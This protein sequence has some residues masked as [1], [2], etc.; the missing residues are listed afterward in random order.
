MLNEVMRQTSVGGVRSETY[1]A[2]PDIEGAPRIGV[3]RVQFT[4]IFGID[5][6]GR[7]PPRR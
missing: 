6:E 5:R 1:G 7:P 3:F 4:H 2:Q